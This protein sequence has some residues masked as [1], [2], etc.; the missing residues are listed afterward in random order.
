MIFNYAS[1]KRNVAIFQFLPGSYPYFCPVK[2]FNKKSKE[3][4]KNHFMGGN[5]RSEFGKSR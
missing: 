1:L 5:T 2:M 4:G 3:N